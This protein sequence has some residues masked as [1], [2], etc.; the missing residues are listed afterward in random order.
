V[1]AE[2]P[3]KERVISAGSTEN[4]NELSRLGKAGDLRSIEREPMYPRRALGMLQDST[5]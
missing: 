4:V 5:P 3:P 2:W 1:Y